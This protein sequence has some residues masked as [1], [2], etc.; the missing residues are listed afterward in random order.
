MKL[1]TTVVRP[2][3]LPQAKAAFESARARWTPPRPQRTN[4]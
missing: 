1:I 2:E 3:R 4:A